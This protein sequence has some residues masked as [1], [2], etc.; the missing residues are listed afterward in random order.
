M[1]QQTQ[2]RRPSIRTEKESIFKEIGPNNGSGSED[3]RSTDSDEDLEKLTSHEQDLASPFNEPNIALVFRQKD[4]V[5]DILPLADEYQTDNFKKTIE[6]FLLKG[7]L[8]KSDSITSVD[9]IVKILE[10]ER[11]KL[12]D[13]LNAC[14][15]VASRKKFNSLTKSPKFEEIS[16]ITQLQISFTRWEDIDDTYTS[17]VN[18]DP[19]NRK[20]KC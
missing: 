13:Y 15:D 5:H 9:I 6:Q 12:N 2:G 20:K 10:A 1:E 8:S 19:K 16:Q 14:M 18:V 11:Y 3:G 7:V 4:T 17:V